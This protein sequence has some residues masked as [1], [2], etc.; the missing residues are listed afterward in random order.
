MYNNEI[1]EAKANSCQQFY[2]GIESTTGYIQYPIYAKK[3][4][5]TFTEKRLEEFY[6]QACMISR[7]PI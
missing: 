1:I 4:D 2:E 3:E 6:R 7:S 5:G